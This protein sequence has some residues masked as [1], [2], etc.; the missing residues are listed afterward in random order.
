MTGSRKGN[1]GPVWEVRVK[2]PGGD[3]NGK[4]LQVASIRDGITPAQGL[5]V[6]FII[7]S[8]DNS[9][10]EKELRAVDLCVDC[11]PS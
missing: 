3:H 6:T 4:K 7:G 9:R 10:Q 8:V 1:N 11:E 2:D 5:N